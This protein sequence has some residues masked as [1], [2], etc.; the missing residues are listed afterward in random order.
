MDSLLKF[1]RY[2][3]DVVVVVTFLGE[4]QR[5]FNWSESHDY[6]RANCIS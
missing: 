2:F 3:T 1:I 5:A 6:V 4:R